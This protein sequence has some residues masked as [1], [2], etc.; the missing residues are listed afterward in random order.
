M[1]KNTNTGNVEMF[2]ANHADDAADQQDKWNNHY[3]TLIKPDNFLKDLESAQDVLDDVIDEMKKKTSNNLGEL[4][5]GLSSRIFDTIGIKLHP[6]YIEYSI[7]SAFADRTA[8]QETLLSVY[9]D[10]DPIT[11]EGIKYLRKSLS[12]GD[13]IFLINQDNKFYVISKRNG[14]QMLDLETFP[15]FLIYM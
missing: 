10:I 15:S 5:N 2:L 4:V 13:N 6:T 12:D 3:S 9:K 14:K 1:Q 7:A 11:I 8:D